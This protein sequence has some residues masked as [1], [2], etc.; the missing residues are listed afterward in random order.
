MGRATISQNLASVFTNFFYVW[1][2]DLIGSS[3]AKLLLK[4][5]TVGR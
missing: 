3:D 4:S 2:R 1:N 5:G